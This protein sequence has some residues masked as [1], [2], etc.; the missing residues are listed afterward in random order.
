MTTTTTTTTSGIDVDAYAQQLYTAVMFQFKETTLN[1]TNIFSL[2]Q[3][4]IETVDTYQNLD[5]PTKKA[6][7][8]QVI[9]LALQNLV[10]NEVDN[11]AL[12][13]L[14]DKFLNAMVDSLVTGPLSNLQINLTFF[15][16][17]KNKMC[18]CLNN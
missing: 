5:G 14:I 3:L 4:S 1:T 7:V 15:T 11:Q 16:N 13:V 8:L 18:P 17:L 9:N 2:L 12:Q 6:L 10:T